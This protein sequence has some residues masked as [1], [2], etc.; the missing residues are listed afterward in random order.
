[1]SHLLT[2]QD[3]ARRLGCSAPHAR[4]LMNSGRISAIDIS[5]TR[6]RKMLRVTEDALLH[7]IDEERHD[8]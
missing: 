1:M 2:A 7:F 8:N 6:S 4:A 3:V 5:L